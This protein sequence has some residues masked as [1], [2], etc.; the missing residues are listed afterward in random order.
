LTGIGFTDQTAYTKL[1]ASDLKSG[2]GSLKI[3][4]NGEEEDDDGVNGEDDDGEDDDGVN[5]GL[6]KL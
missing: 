1:Q 2:D 4:L 5:D 3:D 6:K